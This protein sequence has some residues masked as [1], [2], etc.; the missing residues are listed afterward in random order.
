MQL[1]YFLWNDT[2]ILEQPA[3]DEQK[4][5]NEDYIK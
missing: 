3:S 1:N 4:K 5:Q 2:F